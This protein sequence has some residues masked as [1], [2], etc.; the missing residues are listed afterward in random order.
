MEP[1]PLVP[2]SAGLFQQR[3]LKIINTKHTLVKF[4]DVINWEEIERL[5]CLLRCPS[6]YDL[7][8]SLVGHGRRP[9]DGTVR[10]W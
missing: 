1:K 6:R 5:S 2:Q 4:A 8:Q 3:L 7:S 10:S 9:W